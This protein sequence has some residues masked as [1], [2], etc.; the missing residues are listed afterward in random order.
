M[1]D[2]LP[3]APVSAL[4]AVTSG[5][6]AAASTPHQGVGSEQGAP[7]TG[8]GIGPGGGAATQQASTHASAAAR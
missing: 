3:A 5:P 4:P 8:G 7:L 1:A 6:V 2:R